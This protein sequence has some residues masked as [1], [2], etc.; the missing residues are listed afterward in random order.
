MVFVAPEGM[1]DGKSSRMKRAG[2]AAKSSAARERPGAATMTAE[3]VVEQPWQ[4]R[5]LAS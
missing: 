4:T 3:K 2:E 5:E 1:G